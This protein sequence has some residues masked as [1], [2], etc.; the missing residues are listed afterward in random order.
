MFMSAIGPSADSILFVG[1]I[2]GC[3]EPLERLLR[4][5]QYNPECHRLI[6]VGDTINRGPDNLGVLTLLQA[7]GAE[8][9]LGNHE[10]KILQALGNEHRS[11]WMERQSISRDLLRSPRL[12]HWLDWL[13]RWPVFRQGEDWLAVH[14]GLHPVLSLE[15]TPREFS[16][17]VRVCSE[18]GELPEGWDGHND[19]IPAGYYPWHQLYHGERLVV[20]GH[21][22]RQGL[23]RTSNTWGLD[24]GCV[25]GGWLTGLWY[26]EMRLVQVPARP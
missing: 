7:L 14:G 8:P 22:A 1:D 25:Y 9:I 17:F 23:K 16:L 13:S 21:W 18:R 20:Y 5:A 11:G 24:S 2:Q 15:E 10:Q 4:E 6:P 26:P 3:S 19:T 12:N